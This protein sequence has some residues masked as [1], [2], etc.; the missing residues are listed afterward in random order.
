MA[1]AQNEGR[2]RD[3][4]PRTALSALQ[5]LD[6]EASGRSEQGR[7]RVEASA[8]VDRAV[9]ERKL[10]VAKMSEAMVELARNLNDVVVAGIDRKVRMETATS[11][12]Q[13]AA[14]FAKSLVRAP[15]RIHKMR[16][17]VDDMSHSAQRGRIDSMYKQTIG[18]ET[19]NSAINAL[20]ENFQ[21]IALMPDI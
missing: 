15:N 12:R 17:T 2:E 4:Q 6:A 7:K 16:L 1:D 13:R 11:K 20:N 8:S 3:D 9:R 10:G 5:Q 14:N 18:W 21:S 19:L